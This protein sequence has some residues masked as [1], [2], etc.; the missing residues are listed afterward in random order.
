MRG[1]VTLSQ[2]KAVLL[3]VLLVAALAW[4]GCGREESDPAPET[5]QE[6]STT[7]EGNTQEE[8]AGPPLGFAE[9]KETLDEA[10][11]RIAEAVA[12]EDCETVNE[13]NPLSRPTL[14]T[15]ERCEYLR[16]IDGRHVTGASEY[17]EAGAVIDYAT[18]IG[19]VSAVLIRDEDGLYHVAFLNPFNKSESVGTPYAKEFDDAAKDAIRA[20]R[21]R[22]CD[23][24]LEVVFRRF[25]RGAGDE[26]AI[27]SFVEENPVA[28]LFEAQPDARVEKAGGN[29]AYAFYEVGTP[30][31]ALVMVLA[32]ADEDVAPPDAPELPEGAAKY[33]YVD[34]YRVNS[35]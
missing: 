3:P 33:G 19:T 7:T 15:D 26:D 13:L 24:Y 9:P 28:N 23:A 21:E 22:D 18:G 25:G 6:A 5:T 11:E 17:G 10:Q 2:S 32:R 20:L 14:A 12:S 27:C 16:R 1:N 29:S 8:P 35:R 30:G 4:P 31:A 34:I